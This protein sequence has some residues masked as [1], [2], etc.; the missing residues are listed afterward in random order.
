MKRYNAA[1]LYEE[2]NYQSAYPPQDSISRFTISC[3][4]L[5]RCSFGAACVS[6]AICAT[7]AFLDLVA[8]NLLPVNCCQVFGS[9]N[10]DG[11]DAPNRY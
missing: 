4:C 6:R 7:P 10:K 1:M 5:S 11:Q 3:S 2:M 9:K 8:S